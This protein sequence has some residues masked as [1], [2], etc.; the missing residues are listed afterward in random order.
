MA[1][2]KPLVYDNGDLR[3][4]TQD[5]VTSAIEYAVVAYYNNPSVYLDLVTFN[6]SLGILQDTRN[7]AGQAVSTNSYHPFDR[8]TPSTGTT[9]NNWSRVDEV[10]ENPSIPT[11]TLPSY[12]GGVKNFVDGNNTIVESEVD[13]AV[14]DRDDFFD[15]FIRNALNYLAQENTQYFVSTEGNI[16]GFNRLGLIFTDTLQ[17]VAAYSVEGIP[18]AID[19]PILSGQ[20]AR[21]QNQ[22]GL[23][24]TWGNFYLHRRNLSALFNYSNL[25]APVFNTS[26]GDLEEYSLNEWKSLLEG[27]V[28]Y[29]MRNRSGYRQYFAW[30]ASG[31]ASLG[32][33]YD[34]RYDGIEQ[35][36]FDQDGDTYYSQ[37]LRSG[38]GQLIFNAYTLKLKQY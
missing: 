30:N 25:I 11:T 19:Q 14:M 31:G 9:F 10:T 16:S 38:P 27:W 2:R 37:K 15:T 33:V 5:E 24:S 32:T 13:T 3:E 29:E 26:S 36:F 6:G 35:I 34:L 23:P 18:E 12:L 28:R 22:F 1:F 4:M 21:A 17:D 20:D 8:D 7:V